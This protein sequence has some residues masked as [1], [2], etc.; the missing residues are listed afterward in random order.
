MILV[1]NHGDIVEVGT[2]DELLAKNGFYANLY[3]AQF[4][5]VAA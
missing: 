3:N 5:D 2:H 4:E 1:M